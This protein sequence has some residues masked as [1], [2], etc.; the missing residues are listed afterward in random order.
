MS[1]GALNEETLAM[2]AGVLLSL[3]FSYIPGLG[4]RYGALTPAA[5]RLVIL[6]NQ[7]TCLISPTHRSVQ[8][9]RRYS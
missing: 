4:E 8:T 3:A 5:K 2:A 9:L 6:S 7:A 1:A